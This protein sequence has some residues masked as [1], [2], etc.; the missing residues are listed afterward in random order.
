MDL[1][2]GSDW[3]QMLPLPLEGPALGP[4]FAPPLQRS[5]YPSPEAA[6]WGLGEARW[7][8]SARPG[9]A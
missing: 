2:P 6:C 8:D 3:D 5:G 9:Q 1:L 7:D 4:P